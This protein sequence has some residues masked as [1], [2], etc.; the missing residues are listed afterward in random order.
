MN[1]KDL[2]RLRRRDLL[3][4]LLDLTKENDLLRERNDELEAQ[5]Q[6][7]MLIISETGTL[8]EAALRLNGVFQAAQDA[9]DQY[10]HN[11][12]TRC[13][14]MEEE[15]RRKCEQMLVDAENQ[16]KHDEEENTQ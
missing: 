4:M 11:V 10:T 5:L 12:K 2:K 15:T 16:V 9:C 1:K 14:Q 3:E 7:R 6:D 13:Q 8:A